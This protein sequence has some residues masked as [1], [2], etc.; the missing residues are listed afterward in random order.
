MSP[1][2][3]RSSRRSRPGSGDAEGSAGVFH[4]T[5]QAEDGEWI[6]RQV[7]GAAATKLYRCPGCDQEIRPGT[8]HVVAWRSDAAAGLGGADDRRHWHSPCWAR[9][10]RRGPRVQ[11][12]RSAPRY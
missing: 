10:S 9:R 11:R 5:E 8:P 2:R 1:R 4:A 3:N 12:G 7:T 6:V